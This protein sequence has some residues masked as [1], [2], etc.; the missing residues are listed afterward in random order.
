MNILF[1]VSARFTGSWVIPFLTF[2]FLGAAAHGHGI[3]NMG[4]QPVDWHTDQIIRTMT[5]SVHDPRDAGRVVT[6]NGKKC[7]E[8]SFFSF[9]I[10]DRFAF[11]I[12]ESV[13]VEVEFR[14]QREAVAPLLSY[15]KNGAAEAAV[16][17]EVPAYQDG[18]LTHK[19]TFALGR[20]RFA[21][22]GLLLTDFAIGSGS[23]F[24]SSKKTM[25]ICGISINRSYTTMAPRAVGN[26]AIEVRDET[27]KAVPA[28]VG[29][30]DETGRL[31]LPSED[32]IAVKRL[33]EMVRVVNL[34]PSL[35]PWPARNPSGFYINGSYRAKLPVGQYE[36]VVA[37]GPEYRFVR[38]NFTVQSDRTSAIKIG[39][40]RWNDLP[41]KGWY[42]GDNHIH[43]I[44]QD[45]N[46]DPN[47][48][49]F[50]QAEDVHVANILQ[51]GDI[52]TA[53]WPQYGWQAVTA[54]TDDSYSFVPG[55][56]DPRTSRRGHAISL[57]LN[58]P[59]R[60][61]LHYLLYHEVFAKARAQGGVTGY[62]HVLGAG[63]AFNAKAGLAL[64]VPFGLVDFVEVM[65]G[66]YGG[67]SLWFDFLNLGYKLAPSAGTDYMWDLTLPGAGRSYVHVRSPFSL[68]G[69]FDA[70]KRGET[71]V[72]NGPML[73]FTVNGHSMGSEIRLKSGDKLIINAA[74]SINPDID[75]LKSLEL[76]EQ[77]E[78]VKT[79]TTKNSGTTSLQLHHEVTA[80]QGTWF[81]IRAQGQLPLRSDFP[82]PDWLD[83]KSAKMALS[84]AV[85]VYV[86]GQSFWKPSSVPSIVQ[87][88]KHGMVN[89][90]APETGEGDQTGT[91]ETLLTLWDS[92]KGL[93]QQRIDEV[94][95]IYD[96]LVAKAK[97]ATEQR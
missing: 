51:V 91:R 4:D 81:V 15:E 69:W 40:K 66:G 2:S 53:A 59:I 88:L 28:R 10:D 36:L 89:L 27:G 6:L 85:Y 30:Y 97:T 38:Q 49:I 35:I 29:I 78:V 86:D 73:E 84:G 48:L 32:A 21:N 17:G 39:L 1:E 13:Q 5:F 16:R 37:K 70:F 12:D 7:L 74:A 14:K 94:M 62:A 8:G 45:K 83:Q 3:P 96:D 56:E 60:D 18:P 71:F 55:Q 87:R 25:T 61:P 26:I 63:D 23:H 9:D 75:S 33:D 52:A 58:E 64:D 43:Y 95:P 79:V 57:R 93:L 72:T 67:S 34:N 92:K 47:L 41:A 80:R 77:G 44:R 24:F 90:M 68:Q 31:P 42:S 82:K 46:D 20:A 19:V 22:R 65:A 50:T 54:V 76:I 11:D